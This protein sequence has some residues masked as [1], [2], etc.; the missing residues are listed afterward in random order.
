MIMKLTISIIL[1]LL[2]FCSVFAS[3]NDLRVKKNFVM[4]QSLGYANMPDFLSEYGISYIKIYGQSHFWGSKIEDDNIP[5]IGIIEK[6]ALD[7]IK[8]K[9]SVVCL[10]IEHWPVTGENI[11]KRN[12]SINK[13]YRVMDIF[14][15]VAPS[16]DVGFYST[17]PVRNYWDLVK[18]DG[19]LTSKVLTWKHENA[20]MTDLANRVDIIMPSLY[21]FYNK[22][23]DWIKYAEGMLKEAKK[24]GKP[25]YAFVWPEY[26][27]SNRWL[28]GTAIDKGF[29]LKQLRL[30]Y[31]HADGVI[32]WSLKSPYPKQWDKSSGWWE[33]T[34][35]FMSEIN[36]VEHALDEPDVK[37]H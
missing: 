1:M 25:V 21:T 5:K 35:L 36:Y 10:D 26:H 6:L 16:V 4:Y 7:S 19:E 11:S 24:Y 22:P 12:E 28:S 18:A 9:R 15:K 34:K 32:I 20:A 30:I 33:A 3:D 27:Q 8:N 13:Y 14:K 37:L 17:L 29:W 31:K 23:E 2:P